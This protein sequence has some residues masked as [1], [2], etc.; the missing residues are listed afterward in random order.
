MSDS[1]MAAE[2]VSN[3]DSLITVWEKTVDLQMH[4]N[5]LCLALRRAAVAVLGALLGAGAISFRFGGF[6]VVFGQTTTTAFLFVVVALIVWGAF[7]LIDRYWYHELLRAA[8]S[9]AE[10]LEAEAERLGLPFPLSLSRQIREK[11]RASLRLTGG[12]KLAVF[13]A[14]PATMV[15]VAAYVLFRGYV[16]PLS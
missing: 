15:A 12:Q 11:N 9:Y 10:G 8:V 6:V 13:Y 2:G 3:H 5:D 4:F 14:V 16:Q 1:S 7:F